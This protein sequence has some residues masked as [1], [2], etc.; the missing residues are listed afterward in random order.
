MYQKNGK[1]PNE[2]EGQSKEQFAFL[3]QR[4]VSHFS[5]VRL[6]EDLWGA[7]PLLTI[8]SLSDAEVTPEAEPE[9]FQLKASHLGSIHCQWPL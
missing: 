1:S 6:N 7:D 3:P 5:F 4:A 9:L 8:S 2:G